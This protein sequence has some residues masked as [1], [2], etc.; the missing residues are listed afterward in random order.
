MKTH[1]GASPAI[2]VGVSD[3]RFWFLS[4]AMR[5]TAFLQGGDTMLQAKF[6]RFF[7]LNAISLGA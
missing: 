5:P 3:A 6:D 2:M 1:M 7:A 4:R